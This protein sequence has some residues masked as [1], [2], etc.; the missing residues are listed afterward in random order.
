MKSYIGLYLYLYDAVVTTRAPYTRFTRWMQN[1]AIDGRRPWI[2]LQ[3]L[4]NCR[5]I[6]IIIII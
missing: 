1:S 3:R 2:K 5:I 4:I 6:I